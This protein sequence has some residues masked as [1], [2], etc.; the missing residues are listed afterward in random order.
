MENPEHWVKACGMTGDAEFGD[1]DGHQIIQHS[2]RRGCGALRGF[3]ERGAAR[4]EGGPVSG[5]RGPV[6]GGEVDGGSGETAPIGDGD[7]AFGRRLP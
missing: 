3:G 2:L 5:D 1:G 7:V 4:P 6:A